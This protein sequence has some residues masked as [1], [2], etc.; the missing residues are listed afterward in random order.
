MKE[1]T[2]HITEQILNN[3]LSDCST[4]RLTDKESARSLRLAKT[5]ELLTHEIDK[6]TNRDHKNAQFTLKSDVDTILKYHK[7]NL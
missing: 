2:E 1:M 7:G 3:L 5:L 4:Y 6:Q